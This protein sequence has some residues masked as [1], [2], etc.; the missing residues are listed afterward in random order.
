[1]KKIKVGE[2]V[3]GMYNERTHVLK[4]RVYKS[5][6][7][8]RVG[9]EWGID[10]HM[11]EMLPEDA[12]IVLEELEGHKWYWLSKKEIMENGR[13]FLGYADY[14]LQRMV[15]LSKWKTLTKEQTEENEYRKAQGLELRYIPL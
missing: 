8:F 12:T 14:G 7:F 1:M 4:K 10:Y 5:K 9:G 15:P 3:V 2:K 6:H 13:E 11:L